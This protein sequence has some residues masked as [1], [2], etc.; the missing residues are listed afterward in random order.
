MKII[1]ARSGQELVPGSDVRY[2]VF[3]GEPDSDNYQLL[4]VK[5]GWLTAS[6]RIRRL[7]DGNTRWTHLVVRFTHPSFFLQKVAFVPS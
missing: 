6:A 7:R 5:E 1:D 4:E 3:N 2:P